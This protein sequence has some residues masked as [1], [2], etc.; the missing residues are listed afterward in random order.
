MP[1]YTSAGGTA[2]ARS[3]SIST[4]TRPTNS[5]TNPSRSQAGPS[6]AIF[7]TAD[8]QCG[9]QIVVMHRV[10]RL[11]TQSQPRRD[12]HAAVVNSA[13]YQDPGR[14]RPECAHSISRRETVP[15]WAGHLAHVRMTAVRRF[16]STV[17]PG[18]PSGGA[19]GGQRRS[20]R[21]PQGQKDIVG[22]KRPGPPR[23][24]G[25]DILA[26]TSRASRARAPAHR[27]AER[28]SRGAI[29][30]ARMTRSEDRCAPH[31]RFNGFP[32]T[33]PP[34]SVR[35]SAAAEPL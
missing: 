4:R 30:I 24:S 6:T 3:C 7:A 14:G 9:R 21:R 27:G 31:R 2:D 5:Q 29:E 11:T 34:T 18:P 12:S 19:P 23:G 32:R 35:K 13:H 20:K 28:C 10:G 33:G 26:L 8:D 17:G 16:Y 15:D 22:C 1:R 25:H